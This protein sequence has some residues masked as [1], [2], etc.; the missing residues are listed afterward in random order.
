MYNNNNDT[1]DTTNKGLITNTICTLYKRK[2]DFSHIH[3]YHPSNM[4]PS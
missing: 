3:T 4:V 1:K 2:E